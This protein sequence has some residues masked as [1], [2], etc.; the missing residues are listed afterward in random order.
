MIGDAKELF[1][2][3]QPPIIEIKLENTSPILARYIKLELLGKPHIQE[4]DH[5]RYVSIQSV[6][7]FGHMI[8]D[9]FPEPEIQ[10]SILESNVKYY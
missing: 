2:S 3:N 5:L 10:K 8:K 7:I 1:S 6:E 4:T 9:L